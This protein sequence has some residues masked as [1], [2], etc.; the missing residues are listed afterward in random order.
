MN[1]LPREKLREL[2]AQHGRALCDEPRRLEAFLRDLC[3][4]HKREIFLLVSAVEEHVV[5]DLLASGDG[6]PQDLVLGRLERKLVDR[7]AVTPVAARWAVES[8]ASALGIFDRAG[9]GA[10]STR[11]GEY[12]AG[13]KGAFQSAC[14][15]GVWGRPKASSGQWKGL[16]FTP[17]TV[18]FPPQYELQILSNDR[19]SDLHVGLSP[20]LTLDW[21]KQIDDRE[22]AHLATVN[23]L[24][25]LNLACSDQITDAGLAH[26]IPLRNLTNLDLRSC[27]QITDAGVAHLAAIKNL[28]DLALSGCNKITDTGLAH[29]VA[30]GNLTDLRLSFCD[31]I[32]DAGVAH[33]KALPNLSGLS[34]AQC[35]GITNRTVWHLMEF[36]NLACV[37]LISSGVSKDAVHPLRTR[38]TGSIIVLR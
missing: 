7:R 20:E 26:L 9:L 5:A 37:S 10:I 18:E 4:E 2:I 6:L 30:L 19:H 23:N 35:Y 1:G 13:K 31:K 25:T 17:G 36:P 11:S 16:G 21:R 28:T 12:H 34:L 8:W 14:G 38:R 22:L 29:L 33:L 15:F 27:D 32:T 24:I 3:G